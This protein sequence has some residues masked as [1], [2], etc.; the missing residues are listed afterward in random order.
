MSDREDAPD[1][2]LVGR[3]AERA[4]IDALLE[5][6]RADRSGALVIQ[7]EVGIGKT[8]LLRYALDRA[9]SM[10]VLRARGIESESELAFAALGDFFRPVLDEVE[11]IPRPQADALAGALALGPAM[12]GDRFTVCAATLSLLAAVAERRPV[13][14]L[15]DDGQWLDRSSAE[16]FLFAARRLESE[17]VALLF[18]LRDGESRPFDTSGLESLAL[19]GLDREHSVELL[20][21]QLDYS[22]S[23][24]VADVLAEATGG[25]PLALVELPNLLSEGQL[26][27]GEPLHE[28]LP[29]APTI[30]RAFLRQ[31]EA[32]PDETR[33]ALLI[34][35]ASESR[36]VD[37]IARALEALGL[38]PRSLDPAEEAGLIS[39][40]DGVLDFRHPQLR[41]SVYHE[42]PAGARQAA[43]QALAD[44]STGGR[45]DRRA[46]HLAAAAPDLDEEVAAALESAA[47]EARGRGGHAEAA[48][49][50]ERAARL[51]ADG[52]ERAR[53]LLEAADDSR[54]A[55][56]ADRALELLDDALAAAGNS[57]TRA[58]IQHLRG[59]VEMWFGRP[60]EAYKLLQ[61][62]A[63]R[64][65]QAD[66]AKAA[67]MLTD[68]SWACFMAADIATGLETAE[69]AQKSAD[70]A[71]EAT[72]IHAAAVLGVGLLL[73]GR[74]RDAHPLL[75]RFEP[76]LQTADFERMRQLAIPAQVLTWI[77]EYGLARRLLGK[78]IGA[79][80]EQSALG[81]LPYPLVGLSE[82]DFRTGNWAAAYAGASEGV[83]IAEETGQDTTHGF[84]LVCLARVE[85]AQG[86]AD[87]CRDHIARALEIAPHGIGAVAGQ[88]LSTLGLMELSQ[89]QS[90]N[91]IA[92]LEQ[93]ALRTRE[94]G[95]GEP[96]VI[97]WAPD[98]I[99]ACVRAGREKDA[100]AELELFEQQ[101][102]E[103]ERTWAR[104]ASARCHG[105][106]AAEDELDDHFGRAIELHRTTPTPFELARSQLCFGEQLRRH[107][108]RTDAREPLRS[109]LETFEKLGAEPWAERARAELGA[110]G[111]TARRRDPSASDRLTPQE[112]QVALVVA[113]GATNREAGAALF[114][115]PKTIEAHLGRIY[116]KLDIRSRTELARLLASEGALAGATA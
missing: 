100:R 7:G 3:D 39:I 78:M 88:A 106:L 57:E 70:G 29:A 50:L 96:S 66:P 38:D 51:T 56:R 61:D 35:S 31:I 86:R 48:L 40:D 17:G 22:P 23:P 37:E 104:A 52:E 77:E 4:R 109:A 75:E 71:G 111:E 103:T 62:E 60:R 85:A 8:A 68:A 93:L 63:P 11:S 42:A 28:P 45:A 67:R 26:T 81:F 2:G 44:A 24:E 53:R 94:R 110:S 32:L 107:R 113:Q 1:V 79:A 114:L 55:G 34:A 46:W 64:I 49:A 98:L 112:L 101:A 65:E 10:T 95:L 20:T 83:R 54:I 72:E 43:H 21:R 108:R 89:G 41:A 115:S 19:S 76:F 30:Q 9:G 84:G 6:A 92:F 15:V 73:S 14:G 16:A 116:R 27:G 87:A 102:E 47:V 91:A 5:G 36:Q 33:E 80:R 69:E 90:E 18:G 97:Q 25:S 13:L 74:A 59:A 82:L 58:R 105:L 12:Q 99:E